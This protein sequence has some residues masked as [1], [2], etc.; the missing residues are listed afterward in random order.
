MSTQL[1]VLMGVSGS[2]K[3]TVGRQLA[4]RLE[5][6]FFEGD[7]FHPAENVAKMRRGEPLTDADRG[8]WLA[9]LHGLLAEHERGEQPLVLACSALKAGY[10][11]QLQAGGLDPTFVYLKG[12]YDLIAGRMHARLGHFMPQSLLQSQF[13]ALEE[14]ENAIVV[15][16]DQPVERIVDEIVRRLAPQEL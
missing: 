10:R 16:V 12:D 4:A 5:V 3:T 1:I 7:D 9:A 2:G 14:P 8:P 15:N 13:D 11:G 6:P